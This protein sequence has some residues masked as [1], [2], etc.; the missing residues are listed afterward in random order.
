[1]CSPGKTKVK[2]P[3][4]GAE[5]ALR[6]SGA[7]KTERLRGPAPGFLPSAEAES[8][9]PS[10]DIPRAGSKTEALVLFTESFRKED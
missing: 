9:A 8:W 7:T 3:V 2:L 5:V 4:P 1:M 10:S 6:T